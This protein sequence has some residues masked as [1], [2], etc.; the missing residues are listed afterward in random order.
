MPREQPTGNP[1]DELPVEQQAKLNAILG[2]GSHDKMFTMQEVVSAIK[3]IVDPGDKPEELHMRADFFDDEQATAAT[4]IEARNKLFHDII[5]QE[6][7]HNTMAARTAIKGKRVNILRDTII[8]QQNQHQQPQGFGEW[9]KKK[10][11]L[12]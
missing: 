10:A 12:S 4:E 5:H 2:E 1:F 11:G 6:E 3:M 8:G 7:L 9:A